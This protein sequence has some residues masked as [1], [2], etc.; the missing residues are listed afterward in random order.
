MKLLLLICFFVVSCLAVNTS[1]GGE[2][3]YRVVISSTKSELLSEEL[4]KN[5]FDVLQTY[6]ESVEAIL[7]EK[8]YQELKKSLSLKIIEVA[9]PLEKKIPTGKN[10]QKI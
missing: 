2:P 4:K 10:K 6:K 1:L 5:S 8:D 9:Q 7:S 3:K